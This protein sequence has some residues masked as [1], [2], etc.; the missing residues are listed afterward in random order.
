M[1]AIIAFYAWPELQ[2]PLYLLIGFAASVAI[3]AGRWIHKPVQG[4]WLT[5]AA[6][7]ALYS[8]GDL[9][10][11]ILVSTTGE[12]PFPS[13]ADGPYLVGQLLVV[14]G[15]ARLAT[16]LERGFYRPALIDAALIATAGAFVAWP[17]V[18]D[19]LSGSQVDPISG[20]IAL[21][22]PLM[23]LLLIGVLARHLLEPGQKRMAA[24]LLISG[25]MSWLVADLVYAG[26]S[27]SGSYVSGGILDAGWLIA[28][29]FVGASALHPSMARVIATDETHEATV[30]NGRLTLIG[31]AFLVPV[32][33]FMAHGPLV[34]EWDFV[35]FSI[36]AFVLAALG[37]V[38]L[39]GAL[40]VSRVILVQ[41][42]ELELELLRRSRT[43]R[44]TGLANREVIVDSLSMV[45]ERCEP[46]GFVFL[47][48]DDF[49]RVNDAFGHPVGQDVLREVAERLRSIPVAAAG[50][51]RLGGDE[52]GL[53][54]SPC[55][56][57]AA[58]VA[59]GRA[60][61][62]A[63]RPDVVLDGSGF[64]IHASIGIVWSNSGEL[65][66][67][68]ILARADIAM[69]Q[70]KARG[71]DAYAVFE[72]EMHERALARTRLQSDLD[73]AV[74]RGEIEPWF[75]PIFDVGTL[76]L[77][78][79]EALARWRHPVRGLVP[80]DEF[81]P[82]A[83]MSGSIRD[84]DSHIIHVATARVA[85]WNRAPDERA[86]APCQH[87]AEGSLRS[88]HRGSRRFC[89]RS[90]E[91]PGQLPGRRGHGDRPDR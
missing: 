10:Y 88:C 31:L 24:I 30:S 18:L 19:P 22:Y 52:F 6:G 47:D 90:F 78:G 80:P 58:A 20:L 5:L 39:L 13:A 51:A 84:I 38:R 37:S 9:V 87:H 21:A 55:A 14:I 29:L 83:E 49:K 16:P 61:I 64:R 70:A 48:L 45:V 75:Q 42:Q 74:A 50:I 73:G 59:V 8:F 72:P 85:E 91:P 56:D 60:V 82:I 89:T 7:I 65:S 62:E 63:L 44:L 2:D 28:Y 76:E 81:I 57:Q 79:V 34:H 27:V 41:Q 43:D 77:V 33:T 86:P 54:V 69:Y 25:V 68:E 12:E 32:V 17:L 11:T 26:L 1:G 46:V 66:A 35:A 67:D 36:G 4:G 71:G 53:I 40:H 23:D 15:I 3:V